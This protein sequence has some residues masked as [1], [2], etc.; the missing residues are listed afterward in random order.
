MTAGVPGRGEFAVIERLKH[1]LPGPPE[2]EVWIGDDAAVLGLGGSPVLLTTDMAVAGVHADLALMGVDDLGWRAVAA[3]V[4]DIAAMGGR[5]VHVLVAAAGPP[6]TDLDVLSE[7]VAEAVAAHGCR[8]VGG[9]LSNASEVVVVVSVTGVIEG[10]P[11]PVLR[12]GAVPGDHLLL[13]GPVGASAAGLRT[14]RARAA[15]SRRPESGGEALVEAFLRPRAR[16]AE[17]EAARL[18]GATAMI[19]VSDGL[20]A[21][22]GHLAEA[23]GVGF[24]LEQVP[25]APGATV[26]EALGGGEDY[27]LVFAAADVGRVTAA[28]AAAGLAPPLV[29]GTCTAEP[30]ERSWDGREVPRV[31]WEHGW[32]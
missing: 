18:G 26:E 6:T 24:R 14:L 15:S 22:L 31:G 1:R 17:G 9:D 8:L 19:D 23:S 11:G 25:V 12:S 5:A 10:G 32:A 7:G 20:A 2:G 3:A 27:E 29:I 4:S 13:T 28:F 21:D 30:S 16:L